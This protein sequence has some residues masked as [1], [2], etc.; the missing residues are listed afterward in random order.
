MITYVFDP[1]RLIEYTKW[2]NSLI[3][4]SFGLISF[5]TSRDNLYI[6]S[7]ITLFL[8]FWPYNNEKYGNTLN[9]IYFVLLTIYLTWGWSFELNYNLTLPTP[10]IFCKFICKFKKT[11]SASGE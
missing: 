7:N 3:K 10:N 8:F 6:F 1:P 4:T 9:I 2:I 11:L 5:K